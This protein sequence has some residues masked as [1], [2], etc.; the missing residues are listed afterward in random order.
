MSDLSVF[1]G[2]RNLKKLYMEHDPYSLPLSAPTDPRL[3]NISYVKYLVNLEVFEIYGH[4][5]I[6]VS[7]INRHTAVSNSQWKGYSV[8]VQSVSLNYSILCGSCRTTI[9]EMKSEKK[10]ENEK[11]GV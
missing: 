6:G 11:Y 1:K 9:N 3:T 8:F 7:V 2:T 10:R 5:L 4:F